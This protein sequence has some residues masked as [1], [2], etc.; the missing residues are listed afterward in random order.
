MLSIQA[1]KEM[2]HIK[3]SQGTYQAPEFM[4]VTTVKE[5]QGTVHV[6]ADFVT[7]YGINKKEYDFLLVKLPDAWATKHSLS[8][9]EAFPPA[10]KEAMMRNTTLIVVPYYDATTNVLTYKTHV[11]TTSTAFRKAVKLHNSVDRYLNYNNSNKSYVQIHCH[12]DNY[13]NSPAQV[14]AAQ[15]IQSVLTQPKSEYDDSQK[16]MAGRLEEVGRIM[17]TYN[18]TLTKLFN[19]LKQELTFERTV[20]KL[21]V[22][23]LIQYQEREAYPLD[24]LHSSLNRIEELPIGVTR[25]VY[26]GVNSCSRWAYSYDTLYAKPH[27]SYASVYSDNPEHIRL[28]EEYCQADEY[29]YLRTPE[30]SILATEQ[31][32][33]WYNK[34]FDLTQYK[35]KAEVY[36]AVRE[37]INSEAYDLV[38]ASRD[39]LYQDMDSRVIGSITHFTNVDRLYNPESLLSNVRIN[40]IACVAYGISYED[41]V[42]LVRDRAYGHTKANVLHLVSLAPHSLLTVQDII[43]Y[44]G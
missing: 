42:I 25:H 8:F 1:V 20:F 3:V 35:D 23:H 41:A 33:E 27:Y 4:T 21:E 10:L 16:K 7:N 5:G 30:E 6:Q 38:H 12:P 19:E 26:E 32:L 37:F 11:F 39:N 24:I 2:I 17:R 36:D 40:R 29:L 44:L 28:K 34:L 14:K 15:I 18:Y 31:A 43:E 13:G 22:Q 9:N